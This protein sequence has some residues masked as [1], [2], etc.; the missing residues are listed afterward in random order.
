MKYINQAL[1]ISGIEPKTSILEDFD[2]YSN[3]ILSYSKKF[4]LTGIKN[5]QQIT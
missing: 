5:Q 3:L 1:E 4:N 2:K